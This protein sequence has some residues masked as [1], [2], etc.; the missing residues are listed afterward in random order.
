M[1]KECELDLWTVIL[2]TLVLGAVASLSHFA[3]SLSGDSV[4]VGLFNPINESVWEHLKFMFFPNLLWWIIMYFVRRKKCEIDLHRWI[5]SAAVCL[6]AAPLLVILLFYAYT[7]AL[8]GQS[9]AVDM[10]LAFVCYFLAFLLAA[11]VYEHGNPNTAK[12][13]LS[14]AIVAVM[15][16]AFIVFTFH[17]P[18]LPIFQDTSA[19]PMCDQCK[20]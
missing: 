11:H 19:T 4:L 3:Y 5:I 10:V 8:G 18:E 15:F 7:G 14:V 16:A 2:S 13:V 6:V 1:K 12:A 17:P 9:P 20:E